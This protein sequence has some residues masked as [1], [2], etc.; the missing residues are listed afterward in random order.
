MADIIS[1]NTQRNMPVKGII[2]IIIIIIRIDW[3]NECRIASFRHHLLFT[4]SCQ[5]QLY[6]S[7]VFLKAD[8]LVVELILYIALHYRLSFYNHLSIV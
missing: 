1:D 3:I 5:D 4:Q 6:V 7:I 8:L 2:I